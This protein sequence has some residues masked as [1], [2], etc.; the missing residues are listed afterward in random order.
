MAAIN[1]FKIVSE[2]RQIDTYDDFTQK[3]RSIIEKMG[4]PFV[5]LQQ[6]DLP[7]EDKLLPANK[8]YL[9]SWESIQETNSNICQSLLKLINLP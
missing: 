3:L 1:Q 8:Q 6:K 2:G 5:A 4:I 7:N 9:K